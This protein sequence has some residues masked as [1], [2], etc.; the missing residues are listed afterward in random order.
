MD[1]EETDAVTADAMIKAKVK[2]VEGIK[3]V[4]GKGAGKAAGATKKGG[5][6]AKGVTK[7]A[8][9]GKK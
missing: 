2:P 3:G 5:G 1:A 4:A 7:R 8:S 9:T 6:G